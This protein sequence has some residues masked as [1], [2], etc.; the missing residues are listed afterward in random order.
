MTE[1][2][3]FAA[4]ISILL[5]ALAFWCVCR[6]HRILS[7]VQRNKIY[8]RPIW[9]LGNRIRTLRHCFE[10]GKKTARDVILVD[11]QDCAGFQGSLKD[12]LKLTSPSVHA[13][14]A[15]DY[16]KKIYPDDGKCELFLTSEQIKEITEFNGD[17][18][19]D[20]VCH[21]QSNESLDTREMWKMHPFHMNQNDLVGV[22]IRQGSLAD[23][24]YKNFFGEWQT[25]ES[26]LPGPPY[27]CCFK[28]KSKNTSSCPSNIQPLDDFVDAM[29]SYGPLQKFCVVTDRPGCSIEIHRLFPGQIQDM[30]VFI[31]QK[32]D[33]Q[34]A[35][36]DW[37]LLA[38][39]KEIIVSDISSFSY[40][41]SR[42]HGAKLVRLQKNGFGSVLSKSEPHSSLALS[43]IL[44]AVN[45]N[46]MY[47]NF[48]PIF[49]S[50]WKKLFPNANI[51]IILAGDH[52]PT[53][54]QEYKKHFTLLD[55]PGIDSAFV[56]QNV[57]LYWPALIHKS[58]GVLITDIDM[59][60]LNAHYYNSIAH[61]QSDN[62]VSY[63]QSDEVVGTS[64]IAICYNIAAPSVWAEI[65]NIKTKKDV[66]SALK[67][68]Y[69]QKYLVYGEGWYTDQIILRT[70]VNEWTKKTNKWIQLRDE[71]VGY[72]RFDR[73]HY[74][75][76][77]VLDKQTQQALMHGHYSDFHMLRPPNKANMQFNHKVVDLIQDKIFITYG[78]S[79]FIKSRQRIE[80][81]AKATNMFTKV[82]VYTE[83]DICNGLIDAS[84]YPETYK[85]FNEMTRL[86]GYALWKPFIIYDT[87]SRAR[88][89]DIVVY[90]D[91][92]C[93]VHNNPAEIHKTFDA[94][95]CSRTGVSH[96]NNTGGLRGHR[97][98]YN[99]MDTMRQFLREEEVQPF[100]QHNN[101]ME[102]ESGRLI[103]R[104]CDFSMQ[105]VNAFREAAIQH[106]WL[107]TDT[108]STIQNLPEFSDHRH[109]QS[110]YQLLAFQYGI[111]GGD[112]DFFTWL[113][114]DRIR[115]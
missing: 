9:G 16:D 49:V 43:D 8:V 86:G 95:N 105:F 59:V 70:K 113:T 77:S 13:S 58:R 90:A 107:W 67:A 76:D 92:G 87:M 114:A 56:A 112:C 12:T 24:E 21:I 28:D 111:L 33:V 41:A 42:V 94:I 45:L 93:T 65:F 97:R 109:D 64:Q 6:Q 44:T 103:F 110:I 11:N 78:N 23:Y 63:R 51:H 69:M 47:L 2:V 26:R 29:K 50:T 34:T 104:K 106:P 17:V 68:S 27:Y 30:I 100:L 82:H 52:I 14:A 62:F 53:H 73:I 60:P 79:R 40:E 71:D 89:G 61:I 1:W 96:C 81:E 115:E 19:I 72:A 83:K 75:A 4:F 102:F 46:E 37:S 48:V 55:I 80:K 91:S 54:L 36:N 3:L 5:F 66:V 22:H 84:K 57:R 7:F 20:G 101:A 35:V 85:V 10:L 74:N 31:G 88:E 32:T 39:C 108:Q 98:F 15:F 25:K 99:R 38:S 18:Y